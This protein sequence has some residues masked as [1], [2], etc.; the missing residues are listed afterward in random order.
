MVQVTLWQNVFST[1][2]LN[3]MK[4]GMKHQEH[5]VNVTFNLTNM[6]KGKVTYQR[7]NF[8][9]TERSHDFWSYGSESPHNYAQNS[10]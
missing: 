3:T 10:T 7:P 5:N 8:R 2:G 4:V 6:T 1:G 9:C